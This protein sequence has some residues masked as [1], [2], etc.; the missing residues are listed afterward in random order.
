MTAKITFPKVPNTNTWRNAETGVEIRKSEPDNGDGTYYMVFIPMFAE[1]EIIYVAA[2]RTLREARELATEHVETVR[3]QFAA[4][5]DGAIEADAEREVQ[6][7]T[8]SIK[9]DGRPDRVTEIL[10]RAELETSAVA[11]LALVREAKSLDRQLRSVADPLEQARK[12]FPSVFAM[13]DEPT[14]PRVPGAICLEATCGTCG[15]TYNPSQFGEEH[16]NREDGTECGG[17]PENEGSWH[18]VATPTAA[19]TDPEIAAEVAEANGLDAEDAADMVAAATP[20][21]PR[22]VRLVEFG[23]AEPSSYVYMLDGMAVATMPSLKIARRPRER[24]GRNGYA[25]AG[26]AVSVDG[27]EI[28][29]KHSKRDARARLDAWLAAHLAKL[30]R[31]TVEAQRQLDNA[32]H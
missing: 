14:A 30:A 12:Q 23:A 32:K 5:W 20:T 31:M 8:G 16:F 26:W 13:L 1:K 6:A 25:L 9:I 17:S 29:R 21:L 3:V 19:D 7:I 27:V 24:K 15:E 2:E 22:G 4:A 28:D 10:E 11:C 18:A